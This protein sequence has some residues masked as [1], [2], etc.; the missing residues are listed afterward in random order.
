L[1]GDGQRVMG[2]AQFSPG[3]ATLQKLALDELGNIYLLGNA[4]LP[5][6]LGSSRG[7]GTFVTVLTPDAQQVKWT[8]FCPGIM[9]FGVDANGEIVVLLKGHLQ[10]FRPGGTAPVWDAT[11]ASHGDN[12]PGG[13]AVS[14]QTG[15]AVATGYG[16]TRTGHE[17]YKD[18]YAYA[19]DRAGKPVWALWNPDPTREV[20][21]RYGGNGLMADTTGIFCSTDDQGRVYLALRADG[22]NTVTSRDPAD[23][24]RPLDPNVF[25][26]VFQDGPGYGFHGASMS[27]V[28]FRAVAATGKF[29]KATYLT[30][31]LTPAH[32][33][34]LLITGATGEKGNQYVVGGSAYGFR[35]MNPWYEAPPGGYKGGGFLAIF[36]AEFKLL[37]AGYFPGSTINCVAARNGLIVIG[38]HAVE[39]NTGRDENVPNSP[40]VIYGVP[41]YRP[42][43]PAFGGGKTDGYFAVFRLSP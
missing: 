36:D 24:A 25:R 20:D 30:S 12:R 23:P 2:F 29:E 13:M 15:I 19:F 27:S 22:G 7:S 10:R 21:A 4:H 37:Q 28:L 1:T 9:D 11:L 32:A 18:P 39:R 8:I 35:S 38:G 33:N 43:Q 41:T 5:L 42:V 6:E 31:W 26:G 16:M 34:S 3:A 40:E 17:P 14:P